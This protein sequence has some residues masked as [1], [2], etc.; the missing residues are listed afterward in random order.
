MSQLPEPASVPEPASPDGAAAQAARPS[1]SST[2]A[3][4]PPPDPAPSPPLPPSLTRLIVGIGLGAALATF[5]GFV[6]GEYP[7]TGL[8][9]YFAGVLFALVIAEVILS[10]SRQHN[11]ITAA[12]SAVCTVFGLSLAVWISIGEGIDPLP[13]GAWI[14]VLIGLVV[15]LARGGITAGGLRAKSSR[16]S[17]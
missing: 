16:P 5:G 14:A 3:P 6:L 15:A 17:S 11:R 4:T 9:P 7:F 2:A 10:V 8:T 1:E 12:A 13:I